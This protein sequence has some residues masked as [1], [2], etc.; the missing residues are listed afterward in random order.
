MKSIF[1]D[2]NYYKKEKQ[3]IY[4]EKIKQFIEH[5]ERE[6]NKVLVPKINDKIIAV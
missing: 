6:G 2:T 4:S 5:H 3:H 1:Y